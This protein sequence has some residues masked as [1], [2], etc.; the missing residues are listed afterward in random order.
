MSVCHVQALRSDGCAALTG[1]REAVELRDRDG[2]R[3]SGQGRA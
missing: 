2:R 1:S 3:V